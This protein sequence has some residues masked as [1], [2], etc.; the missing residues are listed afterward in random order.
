MKICVTI[1]LICMAL[2]I[3]SAD[4]CPSWECKDIPQTGTGTKFVCVNR[5]SSTSYMNQ[6]CGKC[7]SPPLKN[8][9]PDLIRFIQ[10][11]QNTY[12]LSYRPEG[13]LL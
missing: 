6:I 4:V 2:A 12:S 10:Y 5:T 7:L 8:I 11:S 13:T 9:L 3:V 1:A